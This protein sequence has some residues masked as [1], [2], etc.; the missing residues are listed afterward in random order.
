MHVPNSSGC[1][2]YRATL[3][4]LH[5][6]HE[7]SRKGIQIIGDHTPLDREFCDAFIFHRIIKPDF[8]EYISAIMD[9]ES[10]VAWQLDDDIWNIPDEYPIKKHL[11]PKDLEIAEKL[12]ERS[13]AIIT[14]T[15]YLADL[16]N[17][18][19]KTFVAP[20]L[21]DLSFFQQEFR[22]LKERK[23]IRIL[24]CGSKS[25]SLD[26]QQIINPVIKLIE[27]HKSNV[28]F[29]FWGH[30]PAELLDYKD[31]GCLSI[32][33]WTEGRLYFDQLRQ[34]EPDIGLAPLSDY[35]FNYSKSNLKSLEMIMAGAAFIGTNLVTYD[36]IE[37]GR[38]GLLVEP[39]D[40]DSWFESIDQLIQDYDLRV[41]LAKNGQH[42]VKQ[43]YAW[44][45]QA[46]DRWI[47]AL[48][49]I[50]WA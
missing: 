47:N 20:N 45:S 17:K 13:D 1:S 10:K 7:L 14:S 43:K 15:K 8:F 37:H 6:Y 29:I 21:V 48:N 9:S 22:R 39:E 24:W 30:F 28:H 27:K 12:K 23:P 34:I 19:Q 36:W 40:E 50:G 46:K 31:T 32:I 44:Q 11:E 49:W 3:P 41:E 35:K 25:H 33:P 4:V 18:P 42:Q 26:L 16:I 5:C 2:L 38:T